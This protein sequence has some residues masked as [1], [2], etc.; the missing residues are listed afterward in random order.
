MASLRIE[1][2]DN[3]N[4]W[5][6]F[7]LSSPQSNPF[8]SI[9]WL[10]PYAE[11]FNLNFEVTF[12]RKGYETIAGIILP[13][14]KKFLLHVLTP[15]PFTYYNGITFKNFQSEKRQKEILEKN[16]SILMLHKHII[17][18]I[19]F[20]VFKLHHTIYDIRQFKWLG[21]KVK[22]RYTF[23]LNLNPIDLVWERM[24]N[25]LKRKIKEAQEVGFRVLKSKSADVL[26][27]QQIL[28]YERTGGKFFLGFDKLKN[29]LN[30]LVNSGI[31]EVYYLIDSRGE[32]LASRGISIWGEKGYD[33]VAG[34]RE[35][36]SDVASHF[37]VWK[38]LE[39]LS[40]RGITEFDFCGAD[41]EKVAFFKMQFGG[42][43]KLSFEVSFA[44][45]I[46]KFF[47]R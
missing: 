18:K 37:L 44:K 32:I 38:I 40:T 7:I 11:I 3:L 35:R 8:L 10:K 26:A 45:G 19:D 15:L 39:D 46:L 13:V 9:N 20:F 16:E 24:S 23:V 5:S 29:L 2:S 22:P 25:S 47:Q 30:E 28:S 12:V 14:K 6:N 21:Y 1:I 41:I 17:K 34:M 4:E 43:L 36:E 31:L 33:I 42:E 27:E